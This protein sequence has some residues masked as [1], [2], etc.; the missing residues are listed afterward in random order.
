MRSN[1]H[2][3][4]EA[5]AEGRK[6]EAAG[7]RP[8]GAVVV[9]DGEIIGRG[10]NTVVSGGDP[11]AHAEIEAIRGVCDRLGAA[12]LV[13]ATIYCTMESCPMCLWAIRVA[14]IARLVL[15]GRHAAIGRSDLADYA[16]EKLLAM[17]GNPIEMVTGVRQAECEAVRMDWNIANGAEA[18][19][20][21]V[22]RPQ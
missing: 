6:A 17:T 3:M 15:G 4:D 21:P 10:H 8:T 19:A 18:G 22:A 5:L 16:A 14:G 1:D 9:R 7:N 12:A 2:F 11:L 20:S 13:G